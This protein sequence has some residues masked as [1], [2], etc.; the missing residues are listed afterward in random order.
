MALERALGAIMALRRRL[1]GIMAL[2]WRFPW[3]WCPSCK[4][5]L[6]IR[7]RL[8][9]ARV[10]R[11]S[12]P[13]SSIDLTQTSPETLEEL[14]KN[15]KE[16]Y[17]SI[18]FGYNEMNLKDTGMRYVD[19][20]IYEETVQQYRLDCELKELAMKRNEDDLIFLHEN[21][22]PQDISG[23]QKIT[24]AKN[25]LDDSSSALSI[26][27]CN[28]FEY[29]HSTIPYDISKY[30]KKRRELRKKLLDLILLI[31]SYERQLGLMVGAD[32]S[33]L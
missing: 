10:A 30:R 1:G 31:R 16:K 3:Q 26:A 33:G 25:K 21:N 29:V 13:K 20:S 18:H 6:Y 17:A 22:H 28:L 4:T 24:T 23:S 5:T 19:F 15:A 11:M 8:V 9:L 27:E 12:S 2:R 7:R 32:L 14:L